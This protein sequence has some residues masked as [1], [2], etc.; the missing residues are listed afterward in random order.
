MKTNWTERSREQQE[1]YLDWVERSAR[2]RIEERMA[3][4]PQPKPPAA[5]AVVLHPTRSTT[6]N[7][8][9]RVFCVGSAYNRS[10]LPLT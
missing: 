8:H 5:V 4:R 9:V 10:R 3:S 1:A 7:A 2:D 6:V